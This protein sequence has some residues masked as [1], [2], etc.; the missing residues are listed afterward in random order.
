MGRNVASVVAS[1]DGRLLAVADGAGSSDYSGAVWVYE[2]A[3]GEVVKKLAGHT[4]YVTDLAFSK[5]GRRLVSV[6]E[7]QTGLVW[8]VTLPALGGA[9]DGKP[10][11]ARLAEAWERLANSDAPPAY[12]GMAVLAA[13]PAET[14]SLLR[15]KLRAAAVPT[16]ADLDRVVRQLD[17]D[18]T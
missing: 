7:D 14:V 3:T 13:A 1:P 10:T 17:D 11:D 18:A 4:G 12:T 8:D 16:E 5:D 9:P 2:T 15:A 6:S